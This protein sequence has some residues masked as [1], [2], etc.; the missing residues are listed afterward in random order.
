MGLG[1]D[2]ELEALRVLCAELVK[3]S[4]QVSLSDAG[5]ALILRGE[6]GRITTV[7]TANRDHYQWRRGEDVHALGDPVGAAGAIAATVWEQAGDPAETS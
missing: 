4:F 5:P 3:L 6:S 1:R 2:P 7:I